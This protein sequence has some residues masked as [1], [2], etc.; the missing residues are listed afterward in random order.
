MTIAPEKA[1]LAI[2]MLLEGSS[3]R[4]IERTID[5]HRDTILKLLAVAGAKC[6]RIMATRVRNIAVK[7]VE[8]DELWSFIAKKEKRVRP[9]DDQNMGDCY[10]FVGI[11]RNTKLVLNIAM[12]K[13]DQL[14]TNSFMKGF[15]DAGEVDRQPPHVFAST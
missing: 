12:G 10:V 15:G 9:E 7:D 11:E 8:A 13:R 1:V 14:T 6:E 4:S 5:I 2:R 3:V